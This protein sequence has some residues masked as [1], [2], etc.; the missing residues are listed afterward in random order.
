MGGVRSL[1]ILGRMFYFGGPTSLQ[2]TSR[3]Y[4]QDEEMG[5]NCDDITS[6]EAARTSEAAAPEPL[7]TQMKSTAPRFSSCDHPLDRLGT[8]SA[9]SAGLSVRVAVAISSICIFATHQSQHSR[10]PVASDMKLASFL[11][12]DFQCGLHLHTVISPSTSAEHRVQQI[13]M[14]QR[15]KP[16]EE[17]SGNIRG[18]Y[19]P[20]R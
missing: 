3:R 16:S 20:Y 14:A 18:I 15:A 1:H 2:Q 4:R 10:F 8:S 19:H 17:T 13:W 12:H 9:K 11:V 5:R 7:T 6:S